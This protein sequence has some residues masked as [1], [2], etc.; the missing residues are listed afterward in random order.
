[1]E[2]SIDAF[3]D[4]T[5]VFELLDSA[6]QKLFSV[7]ENNFRRD[8]DNMQNLVNNA[9][10]DIQSARD[11]EGNLRGIPS[12]FTDLDRITA[13]WQKSDLVILAAR[14]GMGKTAFVLSMARIIAGDFNIHVAFFSLEM[15]S[16]Q[17]VT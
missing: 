17:L 6:E 12:G 16:I 14:P 3:E 15:A 2:V 1:M 8:Y 4:T 5:D 9:I 13:G 10:K 7:S 11:H